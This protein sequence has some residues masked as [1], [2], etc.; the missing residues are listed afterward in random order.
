MK[1]TILILICLLTVIPLKAQ[2]EPSKEAASFQAKIQI[3]LL[4]DVSGSMDQLIAQAQGQLWKMANFLSQLKK[5]EQTPF[6]NW[7]HFL[8]WH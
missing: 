8:W 7:P 3:A 1:N 5:N 2:E 6:R 4:I